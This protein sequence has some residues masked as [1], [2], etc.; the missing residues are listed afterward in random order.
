MLEQAIIDA[1]QLK[2][3]AQQTAEEAVVERYQ[4]EIR[5]A[6]EKILEQEEGLFGD[7]G[8]LDP[9][10]E[11]GEE[12]DDADLEFVDDLPSVQTTADDEIVTIDLNRLE[13]MMAEEMDTEDGLDVTEMVD[14][15]D[16]ADDIVE[17]TED[18]EEM[19]E[20]D[21]ADL[22]AV[23]AE[24]MSETAEEDA[25]VVEEAT[26]EDA[27]VVEEVV[28]EDG[29]V[30]E[31]DK[32]SGASKGAK[33]KDKKDPKARDYVRGGDR[34]GDKGK[35]GG[36]DFKTTK[37]GDKTKSGAKAFNKYPN[38]GDK[39]KG[40]GK[41]YKRDD[42]GGGHDDYKTA[43]NSP[44][45][46]YQENLVKEAQQKV[47]LLEQK[48]EKYG[49]IT[50]K[51]KEKLEESNLINAK[52]LYQN[53]ILNSVS[54]NERQ[55]NKIAEAISDATTVGEAKIIFETLQSAVGSVRKQ[56]LPESLNEVVTRSSSA[57]FPRREETVKADPF[58]ERMRI[59]A[60]LDKK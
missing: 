27:D 30:V 4:D 16:I 24:L 9:A 18:D 25:D 31:E 29:D 59:L 15:E 40:D 1:E 14:R 21:E 32:R 20:L 5:E 6:V 56:K 2:E 12:T 49:K 55:K 22:A 17:S 7:I 39:K 36:Q 51:L 52:L 3:T 35:R 38:K 23:L 26:E 37:R 53:R 44:N 48:L 13:E 57:F 8:D 50:N 58:T 43:K 19:V 46:P 34:E 10:L 28:E 47:Q 54:L 60:G 45:F 11:E 33:G 41:A 42:A